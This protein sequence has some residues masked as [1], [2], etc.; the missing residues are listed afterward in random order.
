MF[1]KR[2]LHIEGGL[3]GLRKNGSNAT[4]KVVGLGLDTPWKPPSWSY[5]FSARKRS[6]ATCLRIA[7]VSLPRFSALTAFALSISSEAR[8]IILI[9]LGPP[10][11]IASRH[12]CSW[13]DGIA[14]IWIDGL[15]LRYAC[16]AIAAANSFS[17][18]TSSVLVPLFLSLP[19]GGVLYAITLKRTIHML[20]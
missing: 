14:P 9:G 4:R 6:L 13:I 12:A 11:L 8:C 15:R 16:S 10:S 17:N 3:V 19:I 7:D 5:V 20:W 2:F 1:T 18:E